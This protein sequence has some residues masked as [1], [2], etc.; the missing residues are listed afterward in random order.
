MAYTRSVSVSILV[1]I[2]LRRR[3]PDIPVP[4]YDVDTGAAPWECYEG[5]F[6]E[7]GLGQALVR[8]VLLLDS[9]QERLGL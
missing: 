3:L 1:Q 4:V 8:P 7:L 5:G 6:V 9:F 2:H